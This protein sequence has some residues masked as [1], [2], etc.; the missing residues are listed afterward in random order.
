MVLLKAGNNSSMRTLGLALMLPLFVCLFA[1]FFYLWWKMYK[2][3]NKR[4]KE[5]L[6]ILN[7]KLELSVKE[8]GVAGSIFHKKLPVV[9][10]YAILIIVLVFGGGALIN[11]LLGN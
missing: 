1:G 9:I 2:S 11:K 6:E 8:N 10:F 5:T 3:M 7:K 4:K